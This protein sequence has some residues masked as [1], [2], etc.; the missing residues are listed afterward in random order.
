VEKY[1]TTDIESGEDVFLLSQLFI[2][3]SVCFSRL[4]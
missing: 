1:F 4:A 3:A 2:S